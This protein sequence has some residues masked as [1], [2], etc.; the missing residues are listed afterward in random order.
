VG[1][2]T[3]KSSNPDTLAKN[4]MSFASYIY[5]SAFLPAVCLGFWLIQV[6]RP[7]RALWYLTI[8]SGIFYVYWNPRDLIIAGISVIANFFAAKLLLSRKRSYWL[9]ISAIVGNLLALGYYKY[10]AFLLGLIKPDLGMIHIV[11]PLGISFFTFTQIAYLADCW[12]AKIKKEQ[13]IVR[14][15]LLFVSFFPHLIAGPI[16]HHSDV[17]GQIHGGFRAD[18][19]VKIA[20]GLLVFS[21]GLFKKVVIAD[22]LS[23]IV[24][25]IFSL[26]DGGMSVASDQAWIGAVAYALQL[27]F[28]FSGY[29]D[30]AVASA[31]FI[32]FRIPFNF[33]SPYQ[34]TSVIEFW[35]RWHITLSRFLRDYLYIPLGGNKKGEGRRYLNVFVTML[36]G[37]I[38]HGAG[39]N[40][41]IWGALHGFFIV[42]NHFWRDCVVT[43][44]PTIGRSKILSLPSYVLTML[45]VLL[46]WVFFR[47][48]TVAGALEIAEHMFWPPSISFPH[49]LSVSAQQTTLIVV[50]GLVATTLPNSRQ[51]HDW[52]ISVNVH[53][54]WL[55]GA[56]A[57]VLFAIAFV[58]ISSD[59]PFLYFQ[60]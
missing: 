22:N 40:F 58:S 45:C 53:R 8:A 41:V 59:S 12:G 30:M 18:R 15:Y 37:G 27:Y 56:V 34:A 19:E 17:F 14:D 48:E 25:P 28:D 46:G 54:R 51:I 49:G 24:K 6:R 50:A 36:L 52:S 9:F 32:G 55:V 29:S 60:F 26:A 38:W 16:L 47:S 43:A 2:P 35:R 11:L 20:T 5:I 42:V 33:F 21:I 7:D 13:H 10:F 39:I 44:V 1:H 4:E 57:G 31:L 3:T 23:L